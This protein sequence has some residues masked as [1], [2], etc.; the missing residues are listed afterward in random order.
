MIVLS[1]NKIKKIQGLKK[2]TALQK[3]SIS[4]NNIREL[5]G[6]E[7]NNE[8]AQLRLN[9]NKILRIP[10]TIATNSLLS[11]L[12]LGNNRIGGKEYIKALETL[13]RLQQVNLKSNPM[14]EAEQEVV[15]YIREVCGK[16]LVVNNKRVVPK[17]GR[18][19][20][21]VIEGKEEVKQVPEVLPQ[22]KPNHKKFKTE[23]PKGLNSVQGIEERKVGKFDEGKNNEVLKKKRAEPEENPEDVIEVKGSNKTQDGVKVSGIVNVEKRKKMKKKRVK[24][25]LLDQKQTIEKWN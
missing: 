24:E 19:R 10:E 17:K 11:I 5:A 21:K 14:K 23:K 12:D 3:L 4:H 22:I 18:K 13:P 9:N 16:I 1:H 25:K 15:D 20:M 6:I 2:L 7:K 8:L